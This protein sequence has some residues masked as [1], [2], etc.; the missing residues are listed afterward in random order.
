MKHLFNHGDL[1]T[2]DMDRNSCQT[3]SVPGKGDFSVIYTTR[4]LYD[5]NKQGKT[6]YINIGNW[7]LLSPVSP[8]PGFVLSYLSQLLAVEAS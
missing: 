4:F 7:M 8:Y 2:P 3:M 6:C 1:L 5:L